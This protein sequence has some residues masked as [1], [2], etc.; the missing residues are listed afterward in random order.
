MK[1]NIQFSFN[2]AKTGADID[3]DLYNWVSSNPLGKIGHAW[4][5]LSNKATNTFT[6]QDSVRRILL[7]NPKVG[8]TP[9]TSPDWNRK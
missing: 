3:I 6:N 7:A 1:G 4:E 9:S 5:A 2:G 8:I